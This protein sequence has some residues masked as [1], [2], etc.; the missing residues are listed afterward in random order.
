MK[1]WD[2]TTEEF[3]SQAASSSPTPGGGSVSAYTGALAASMVCMVANLTIG[4]ERYQDVEAEAR[5]VL[6]KGIQ[7]MEQLKKN[8]DQDIA[9]FSHYMTALKLP[10]MT[11]EEKTL[12]S[13]KLQEAL[14]RATQVPL[15]IGQNCLQVLQLAD[16][17]APIGNRTAISDIG[18]AAYLAESAIKSAM[19][20][21]DINLPG[22]K[23]E[24]YREKATGMKKELLAEGSNLTQR[25]TGQIQAV[26]RA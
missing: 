16:I 6:E 23:D 25:I 26:L 12:R 24:D 15:E 17:L 7:V 4:K 9:E 19:L 22:I 3:L 11:D 13:A 1:V 5:K 18:V 2:W 21:V 14:V 8:L 20:N 10:K